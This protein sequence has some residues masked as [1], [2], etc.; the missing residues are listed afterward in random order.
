[1]LGMLQIRRRTA[2]T[3]VEVHHAD[4]RV[5]VVPDPQAAQRIIEANPAGQVQAW[6]VWCNDLGVGQRL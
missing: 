6:Q 2:K 5:E 3:R 1:M 4:G